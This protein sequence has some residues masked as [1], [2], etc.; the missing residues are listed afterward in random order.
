MD[1]KEVVPGNTYTYAPLGDNGL[2]TPCEVLKV[3]NEAAIV[4]IKGAV[5]IIPV[6]DLVDDIGSTEHP[7]KMPFAYKDESVFTDAERS[8]YKDELGVVG[9]IRALS[10]AIELSVVGD[11]KRSTMQMQ[12]LALLLEYTK[13]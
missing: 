4:E 7:S 5:K 6:K 3:K 12:L 1:A 11:R 10:E 2:H 9:C 13:E 8:H